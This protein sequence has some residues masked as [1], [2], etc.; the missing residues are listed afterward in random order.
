M[1]P[2][3]KIPFNRQVEILTIQRIKP[4]LIEAHVRLLN[5]G[6]LDWNRCP[7]DDR[8]SVCMLGYRITCHEGKFPPVEKLLPLD[9][10]LVK[11]DE[12]ILVHLLV[13]IP[14]ASALFRFEIDLVSINR[15]GTAKWFSNLGLPP[16][17]LELKTP[18]PEEGT[19]LYN[20]RFTDI[21]FRM[22]SKTQAIISGFIK[23]TGTEA[24][25]ATSSKTSDFYLGLRAFNSPALELVLWEGRG[26]LEHASIAPGEES[27]FSATVPAEYLAQNSYLKLC[28]LKEKHFWFDDKGAPSYLL[29]LEAMQDLLKN[30]PASYIAYCA[31][32][33]AN[34]CVLAGEFLIKIS[35]FLKNSGSRPWNPVGYD[36]SQAITIGVRLQHPVTTQTIREGRV[37]LP[38]RTIVPDEEI[39]FAITLSTL[40]IPPGRYVLVLDMV[41][42][43]VFWFEQQGSHAVEMSLEI[44]ERP[45]LPA[46]EKRPILYRKSAQITGSRILL[47]APTLPLFDKQAGGQRLFNLLGILVKLGFEVDYFYESI[48]DL[49]DAAR[50][51]K[52]LHEIGIQPRQDALLH[53]AA[54]DPDYYDTCILAWHDCA[55]RHIAVVRTALPRT[56][57]I[58]DTVDVHWIREARGVEAGEL[59]FSPE[60]LAE[61]KLRES[62]I[63]READ[64]LWVVT[65]ADRQAIIDCDPL[66]QHQLVPLIYTETEEKN[67]RLDGDA[68]LFVGGFRHPPNIAA[69]RRSA[70]ICEE[71]RKQSGIQA[72]LFIVGES[73]PPEI[74]ALE[75]QGATQV[76]GFVADLERYY[77]RSRVT[78]APLQSG[79]GMK[80]KIC[81]AAYEGVPIIASPV[82]VE[83]LYL[84]DRKDFFLAQ[85]D[86]DFIEALKVAFDPNSD[87]RTMTHRAFEK[88]FRLTSEAGIATTVLAGLIY[89][90]VVIAIVSWN[91]R[92]LLKKCIDSIIEKTDFPDYR[93]AIVSNGCIDGTREL[94]LDYQSRF[95]DL[96]DPY[97]NNENQFFIRPNNFILQKYP[98]RDVVMV[99]N[100]IEIVTQD[101]LTYLYYGAYSSAFVGAAGGMTIN[102]EG[103]VSEA[104]AE[105]DLNGY[106]HNLGRGANPQ[107]R[108]LLVQ[109]PVSFCSGCLLY[110]R[111]DALNRFGMLNED[112]NPMYYED[113]EWQFRIKRSG[114]KTIYVPLCVARH[115]EGSSAGTDLNTG[116]KRFQEVNRLKF[117]ATGLLQ[118]T[119]K[120]GSD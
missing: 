84:E 15:L 90:P 93:I 103:K 105:I 37:A 16:A 83:G 13:P 116:M 112:F 35:G 40:A 106:G 101:W 39:P 117:L 76:T 111:R 59:N 27:S 3:T 87:L 46:G 82:A 94:L 69:A 108:E 63:Y 12:E 42:E 23:N 10:E 25:N 51:I 57:V 99:N 64:L 11:S 18:Q 81:D 41:Y 86:Y 36:P 66:I 104:G 30:A 47:I 24:W 75:K 20:S 92:E 31:T 91:R 88:I 113:V 55:E 26:H 1:A 43:S 96:I 21:S 7:V 28:M 9:R 95:P 78:I 34:Q 54:I 118:E 114:F 52:K 56:K 50:Y 8:S 71:F 58:I 65:E 44:A 61:R 115:Y 100:D 67:R 107:T 45:P 33:T 22:A 73:P 80:G 89:R 5:S 53:L 109:R 98:D 110:L 120:S 38:S 68:V 97:F 32:I 14:Q 2:G 77:K 19:S 48:G 60:Q 17:T 79:A 6:S 85:T 70:I 72:P 119:L 62:T 29:D 74:I 49:P 102:A 4:Q